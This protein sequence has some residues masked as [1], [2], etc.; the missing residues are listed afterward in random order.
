MERLVCF[1]P[2]RHSLGEVIHAP[3]VMNMIK[4]TKAAKEVKALNDFHTMLSNDADRACYGTKHVEV[5]HERM[6]I[7]TL[8]I[9]DELF[10]NSDVKT[11][12]QY[13][14][15]VESVKHS[16]GELLYFL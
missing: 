12:K 10:R 7:Q 4:D 5:A 15:L 6:A 2:L 3:N 13:V 1:L 14:N 16:G 8:L 9:T 11:R